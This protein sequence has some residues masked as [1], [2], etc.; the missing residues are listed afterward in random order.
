M[1]L[2]LLSPAAPEVPNG[3]DT[4]KAW[5]EGRLR[6]VS[7]GPELWRRPRE[8]ASPVDKEA[9]GAEGEVEKISRLSIL[10]NFSPKQLKLGLLGQ[11]PHRSERRSCAP[12][13]AGVTRPHCAGAQSSQRLGDPQLPTDT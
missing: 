10:P 9:A 2:L 7:G 5:L 13:W 4:R 8:P 1:L 3:V 11:R 6:G 12:R